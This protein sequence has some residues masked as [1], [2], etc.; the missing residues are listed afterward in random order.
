LDSAAPGS[1]VAIIVDYYQPRK[2]RRENLQAVI[3]SGDWFCKN[4]N[5]LIN[6]V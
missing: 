5:Q 1:I 3:V 4:C 6:P 2:I